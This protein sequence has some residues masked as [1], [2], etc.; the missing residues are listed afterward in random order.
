M[1]RLSGLAAGSPELRSIIRPPAPHLQH[2]AIELMVGSQHGSG[3]ARRVR[4]ASTVLGPLVQHRQAELRHL[5]S[6]GA[7]RY[8]DMIQVQTSSKGMRLSVVSPD[9]HS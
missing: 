4:E 7:V 2:D 8:D 9:G 3:A 5:G 1:S 6:G